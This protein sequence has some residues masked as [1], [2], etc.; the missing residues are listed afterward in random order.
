MNAIAEYE[1]LLIGNRKQFS[2]KIFPFEETGNQR[3]ALS[4]FKYAIEELLDWTPQE[5]YKLLT[6]KVVQR[7]KL[8]GLLSYIEFPSELTQSD[9]EYIVHLIYPRVIKY[10][11]RRYVIDVYEKVLRNE[12]KYP[13]DYMYGN[14]GLIRASICLQYAIKVKKVFHSIEEMYQ[15]FSSPEGIQFLKEEKLRQLYS[16]FYKTPLDYLH[17]SLPQNLKSDFYYQYYKFL[18]KFKSMYKRYPVGIEKAHII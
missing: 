16:S 11:F 8:D 17:H 6:P 12:I 18:Y 10:D 1:R 7:M 15:F 2:S 14:K 9:T 13:K 3:V 5:A 4:I